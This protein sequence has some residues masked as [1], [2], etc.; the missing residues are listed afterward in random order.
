M[1]VKTIDAGAR[2]S[3]AP[4]RNG[5]PVS[6]SS[7][8]LAEA[9]GFDPS[10]ATVVDG[11]LTYPATDKARGLDVAGFVNG[12]PG[13]TRLERSAVLTLAKHYATPRDA[14]G[15][16][17]GKADA[18]LVKRIMARFPTSGEPPVPSREERDSVTALR[19]DFLAYVGAR[20]WVIESASRKRESLV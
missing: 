20:S 5:K 17:T 1:A 4:A 18:A 12:K 10:E 15:N 16:P 9:R 14:D 8:A 19:D 2:V 7:P 11:R 6:F 13:S 3:I